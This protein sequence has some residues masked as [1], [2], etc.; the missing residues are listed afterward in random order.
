MKTVL[1]FFSLSPACDCGVEVDY[2]AN[3]LKEHKKKQ[4]ILCG[5]Y[6]ACQSFFTCLLYVRASLYFVILKP[7][8]VYN[9]IISAH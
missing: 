8:N 6:F 7:R 9:L 3:Y 1:F 5:V 4:S 2:F